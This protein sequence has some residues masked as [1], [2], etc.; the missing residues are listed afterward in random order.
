MATEKHKW[1]RAIK[2]KRME[3]RHFKISPVL[4]IDKIF[5]RQAESIWAE[6]VKSYKIM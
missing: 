6:A 3:L 5:Y 4:K 1:V 2:L